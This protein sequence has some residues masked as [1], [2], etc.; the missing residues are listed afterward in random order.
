VLHATFATPDLTTFCRLDELGL[1][2]TGQR[3]EAHRA[4]LECR[5]ADP[6]GWCVVCGAEGISRGTEAR[7]LAHVP[8]G[9]RPT[10]LLVRVPRWRCSGCGGSWRHDLSRA[11]EPR[12]KLS[13]GAVAWDDLDSQW[14]FKRP[15]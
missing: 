9:G 1:V 12:S 5:V 7:R 8:F 4:V 6:E 10:T 14:G 11:A 13:R 3:I 2:A 15:V